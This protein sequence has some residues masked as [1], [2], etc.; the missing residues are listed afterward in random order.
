MSGKKTVI[1]ELVVSIGLDAENLAKGWSNL[2][3]KS[4]KFFAEVSKGTEQI[5][6]AF[7]VH[8]EGAVQVSQRSVDKLTSHW[9]KLNEYRKKDIADAE[10]GWKKLSEGEVKFKNEKVNL[11]KNYFDESQQAIRTGS[12]SLFKLLQ[13]GAAGYL[14][15]L[16]LG[17]GIGSIQAMSQETGQKG[18][19][20]ERDSFYSDT[21]TATPQAIKK[22]LKR[23]NPDIDT[24]IVQGAMDKIGAGLR[25]YQ[26]RGKWSQDFET[27]YYNSGSVFTPHNL[28]FAGGNS[29]QIMANM[30]E[31]IKN[32]V[33]PGL[34][35]KDPAIRRQARA[36]QDALWKFFGNDE[37]GEK[38][39][40]ALGGLGIQGFLDQVEAEKPNVVFDENTLKA[41]KDIR[42]AGTAFNTAVSNF[43][44]AV[45]KDF[46][47]MY[48]NALNLL[49]NG[50]KGLS[51][52]KAG[53]TMTEGLMGMSF[54]KG[55]SV[56]ASKFGMT[57]LAAALGGPATM[58]A[59]GGAIVG[60]VLV[61][62]VSEQYKK[63]QT[64]EGLNEL[65]DEVLARDDEDGRESQEVVTDD[66]YETRAFAEY[67]HN[68]SQNK[69]DEA[70]ALLAKLQKAL[71][72]SEHGFG[73]FTDNS[74]DVWGQLKNWD[75]I[76]SIMGELMK[77]E[78]VLGNKEF[79]DDDQISQWGNLKKSFE[80]SKKYAEKLKGTK[81]EKSW[82]E[83]LFNPDLSPGLDDAM[84]LAAQTTTIG[85]INNTNNSFQVTVNA[86]D[87]ANATD[88][89]NATVDAVKNFM[90][91][92]G[93][94]AVTRFNT[95]TQ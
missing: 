95:G 61:D 91:Y 33:L 94:S 32:T 42:E 19:K 81:K 77:Y 41:A 79:R 84:E 65:L 74:V 45:T 92:T 55:A 93:R 24:D 16:G 3:S 5:Q 88:V 34:E 39:I 38:I 47:P 40:R 82:W 52:D 66:E 50:I 75:E 46:A 35:S 1:E 56:L 57:K 4:K 54:L 30:A 83:S 71:D 64:K 76:Q 25:E 62:R 87:K 11:W 15:Y 6:K 27:L 29:S 69:K 70:E 28:D 21:D 49:T 90:P 13:Q 43:Q 9:Q 8:F 63:A 89:A 36:A 59:A 31:I 14:S 23:I 68:A 44:I 72:M 78:N 80:D 60:K 10:S 26:S 22:L 48:T 67:G 7:E 18:Y 86:N 58:A 73:L 53:R 2:E 12:E 17:A 51:G 20:V 37:K 85:Q